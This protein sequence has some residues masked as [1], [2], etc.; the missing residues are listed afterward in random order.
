MP[1]NTGHDMINSVELFDQGGDYNTSTYQFTAPVTGKY[2]LNAFIRWNFLDRDASYYIVYI[3][4]S[5]R[6]YYTIIDPDAFDIDP[7]YYSMAFSVLADM[8]ASDTAKVHLYQAGGAQV[9]TYDG[10][11]GSNGFTGYLVA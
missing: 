5:N 10:G 9:T 8:D 6:N 11:A 2:Q 3:I 7:E 1:V 4:T